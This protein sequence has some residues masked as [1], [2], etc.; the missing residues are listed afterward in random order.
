MI[1]LIYFLLIHIIM[2]PVIKKEEST[3]KDES[4][5]KKEESFDLKK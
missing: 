1:L 3:D 5:D 4:A 2:K